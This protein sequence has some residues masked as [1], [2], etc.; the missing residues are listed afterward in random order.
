MAENI[1]T[2]NA[3]E[4]LVDN[5]KLEQVFLSIEKQ[6]IAQ[7]GYL[8]CMQS[9]QA[10]Q[11][12]FTKEMAKKTEARRQSDIVANE[13]VPTTPKETETSSKKEKKK[14]EVEISILPLY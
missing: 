13:D 6:L 8:K 1:A 2:V 3:E 7:T 11:F 14:K 5:P 9:L 10:N 4:A 12:Q